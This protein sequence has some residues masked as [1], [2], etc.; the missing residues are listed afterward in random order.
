MVPAEEL[1]NFGV[2]T[3]KT[4]AK[5]PTVPHLAKTGDSRPVDPLDSCLETRIRLQ[6]GTRTEPKIQPKRIIVAKK[7]SSRNA[8]TFNLSIML[9]KRVDF[10]FYMVLRRASRGDQMHTINNRSHN[11]LA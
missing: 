6:L 8:N 7:N 1:L 9:S 2:E 3:H 4:L 10:G 11:T 5:K